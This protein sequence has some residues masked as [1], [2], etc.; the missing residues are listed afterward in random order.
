M[1]RIVSIERQSD[2]SLSFT[3]KGDALLQ[4]D[5]PINGDHILGKAFYAE[6]NL[7]VLGPLSFNLGSILS[8]GLYKVYGLLFKIKCKARKYLNLVFTSS[9]K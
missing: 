6:K 7:P 9:A 5:V 1:H 2:K 4:E 3:T 8:L